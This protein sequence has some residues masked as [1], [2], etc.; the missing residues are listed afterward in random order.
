MNDVQSEML[1]V[2]TG[3]PQGSILGPLLFII[4]LKDIANTSNLFS[5]II[6]AD[7]TTFSTTIEI[8]LNNT[9]NDGVESKMYSEIASIND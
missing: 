5:F 7:G 6:Y 4:Y 1:T 2:T 3:V 9:N 8:V